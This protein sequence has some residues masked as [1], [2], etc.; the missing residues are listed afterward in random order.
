MFRERVPEGW[1]ATEEA[2][3]PQV[4]CLV[5]GGGVCRMVCDVEVGGSQVGGEKEL[6]LQTSQ[7]HHV[8]QEQQ[9]AENS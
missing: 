4:L 8:L 6:L 7:N 1:A 5:L 9:Q 3:S 2:P